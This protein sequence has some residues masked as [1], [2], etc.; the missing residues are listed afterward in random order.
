MTREEKIPQTVGIKNALSSL[1]FADTFATTNNQNSLKEIAFLIFGNA[2]K[3][4]D[5]LF[6]IR[7]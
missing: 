7:N 3:W 1:D 2:P 4:V 6:R 5:G